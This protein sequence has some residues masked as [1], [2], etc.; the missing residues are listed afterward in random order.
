MATRKTASKKSSKVKV[1]LDVDM[2]SKKTYK[3]TKK[4]LKKVSVGALILA[5]LLLVAGAFGGY[6]GVKYLTRND[7]FEIVGKDE[8]T[9]TLDESYLDEGVKVIAFGKN[10][11]DKVKVTTNLKQNQDGKYYAETE[12]TY[13][14][15]YNVESLKY[16]TIFKVQK[17]RLIT[18][19]EPT[20]PGEMQNEGGNNE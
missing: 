13:Y 4:N 1:D 7:C 20:E 3:R 8:I 10:E 9:L 2:P 18:F 5:G 11:A 12:G 19:V 15:T 6:F 17:V 16:G 14:I